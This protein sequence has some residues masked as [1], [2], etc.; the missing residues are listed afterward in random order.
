[1]RWIYLAMALV[2]AMCML[3]FQQNISTNRIEDI[4]NAIF[5]A[6]G[7]ALTA[8]GFTKWQEMS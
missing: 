5:M 7:A 3:H 8:H 6:C 4:L 2:G 1:M